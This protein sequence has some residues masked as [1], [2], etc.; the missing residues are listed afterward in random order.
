MTAGA[1]SVPD[2]PGPNPAVAAQS[3]TAA[4]Q[5]QIDRFRELVNGA[6]PQMGDE[7][8]AV[9]TAWLDDFLAASGASPSPPQSS[10][11]A[12]RFQWISRA[13]MDAL[14]EACGKPAV[15]LVTGVYVAD[16]VV[17]VEPTF[18]FCDVFTQE[19][20]ANAVC[21]IEGISILTDVAALAKRVLGHAALDSLAT[22]N[23]ADVRLWFRASATDAWQLADA[24]AAAGAAAGGDDEDTGEEDD[25]LPEETEAAPVLVL[26]QVLGAASAG[27]FQVFVDARAD[28]NAPWALGPARAARPAVPPPLTKLR[29]MSFSTESQPEVGQ[30]CDA[31]KP[32]GQWLEARLVAVD[33]SSLT[34]HW[35]SFPASTDERLPRGSPRVLPRNSK[36]PDWRRQLKTDEEI[37]VHKSAMAGRLRGGRFFYGEEHKSAWTFG[38]AVRIE[39]AGANPKVTVRVPGS[40]WNQSRDVQVPLSSEKIAPRFTHTSRPKPLGAPATPPSGRPPPEPG[41]VGLRN[42]GNTCYLN[43]VLQCV[44]HCEP[45]VEYV[46]SGAY[47]ADINRKNPLGKGG[48]LA[49]AFADLVRTMHGNTVSETAPVELRQVLG[50]VNSIFSGYA[51]QD[52]SEA[53][54]FLSDG[55][56]E[57]LNRV[58]ERPAT[59]FQDANG[60]PDAVVARETWDTFQKRDDSKVIDLMRGLMRSHLTCPTCA[61]DAVK[62]DPYGIVQVPVP[63]N[64]LLTVHVLF[65]PTHA[66]ECTRFAAKLPKRATGRDLAQW[67]SAKTK[68]DSGDLVVVEVASLKVAKTYYSRDLHDEPLRDIRE[69]D[70]IVAYQL[71][72][73]QAVL[74]ARGAKRG[75]NGEPQV[76]IESNWALFLQSCVALDRPLDEL[77]DFYIDSLDGAK[78]ASQRRLVDGLSACAF[79]Y[80]RASFVPAYIGRGVL[81]ELEVMDEP[82]LPALV[83]LVKAMEVRPIEGSTRALPSPAKDVM[84]RRPFESKVAG[85][86]KDARTVLALDHIKLSP[87]KVVR[88]PSFVCVAAD[89]SF[90][91]LRLS[92][93]ASLRH[94]F[95]DNYVVPLA[96]GALFTPAPVK[97]SLQTLSPPPQSPPPQS[98][99][100]QS[101]PPQSSPPQSSPPQSSPPQ[102]S[103]GKHELTTTDDGPYRLLFENN[104]L[105]TGTASFAETLPTMSTIVVKW[106]AEATMLIGQTA[107]DPTSPS[108]FDTK[109][110]ALN[111]GNV[112]LDTSAVEAFAEP[113]DAAAGSAPAIS[114]AQCIAQFHQREQLSADNEWFCPRCKALVPAFKTLQLWSLPPIL[115]I[116][117]KRFQFQQRER[118]RAEKIADLVTFPLEALDMGAYLIEK[119]PAVYDLFA[120]S[121]HI[122]AFGSGHYTAFVKSAKGEWWLM[123][124]TRATKVEGDPAAAIVTPI[125]Y[126]LF[127]QIRSGGG[128][129]GQV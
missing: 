8:V 2:S 81:D 37:D 82:I 92:I 35:L 65:V 41:M 3:P 25:D 129:A 94:R 104:E 86:K 46:L 70:L 61:L 66:K 119:R 87:Y 12:G 52:S 50:S 112:V 31:Q 115:V 24:A 80:E 14:S 108:P 58:K 19:S 9:V 33:A 116:N 111:C 56:H 40:M 60:R 91:E 124:D 127:Y 38:K 15:P 49:E 120:V 48:Q 16:G 107:P 39:R 20:G 1:N 114:L 11:T 74:R 53:L 84:K 43:S 26:R 13:A 10:I 17:E 23:E 101:P 118:A 68:V 78:L 113:L 34:V 102:S 85:G 106:T 103:P 36:V 73:D 88:G 79:D 29:S 32:N 42:L 55:L 93:W 83:Q 95:P 4:R 71:L 105:P 57:D 62:F 128:A 122:G 6:Q 21:R 96:F 75:R 109:D 99:P 30:L 126:M 121:N 123:D 77:V 47:E 97:R 44:T 7:R 110:A 5:A 54:L 22:A 89:E 98:S 67:L 51:Q 59:T 90:D 27:S 72:S 100:P 69:G 125:A 76:I 45:L 28:A 18:A 63:T 64:V 117:L